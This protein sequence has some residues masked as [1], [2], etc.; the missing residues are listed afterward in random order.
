MRVAEDGVHQ[1]IFYHAGVGTSPGMLDA[2]TGGATG[3]GI[4]EVSRREN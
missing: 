2:I 3:R 1:I 4:S